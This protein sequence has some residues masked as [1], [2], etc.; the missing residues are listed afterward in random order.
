MFA[1]PDLTVP[2]TGALRLLP[3][4]TILRTVA[5]D[6]PA[7]RHLIRYEQS[8]PSQVRLDVDHPDLELWLRGWLP[9]QS[10]PL[11]PAETMFTVVIG[12]VAELGAP[13]WRAVRA[14]QTRILGRDRDHRLTNHGQL[15][16]V[17]MHATT[18]APRLTD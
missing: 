18:R 12:W 2:A 14:G 7:W 3:P 15:P 4:A 9:G 13:G 8:E 10:A 5:A 6:L 11:V 16:A 17:T 1:V